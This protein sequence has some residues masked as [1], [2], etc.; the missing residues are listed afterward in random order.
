MKKFGEIYKQKVNEAESRQETKVLDDFK[1]VYGA[2]LEHYGLTSIHQLD[3]ESQISF[4][5]E[6]NHYWGEEEGLSEKGVSFLEKRSASLNENSTAVQKKNF[7]RTKSYAVINETFRQTNLKYRLYDVI[8]EM[9]KSLK[10]SDISDILT[11]DMITNI[12]TESF[13]KAFEE[14]MG[15]V[16]KE[17][18]ES[19]QPKRKY[20]VRVK[21]VNER[22]FSE[23]KRKQLADEG[24]AMSDGSFPIITVQDLKNAIKAHGRAKDVAKAKA[25]IKKRAK[26]LGHSELIPKDWK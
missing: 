7:L 26:A 8:D 11:P 13:Y 6:L 5:T 17:L 14:F 23:T 12:I 15:G 4:L 2:M 1:L 9:Y 19:V 21:P 10:A 16:K 22:L 24:K 25:H 20:F 3:E 18:K